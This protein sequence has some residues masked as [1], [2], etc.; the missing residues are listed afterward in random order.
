MMQ[1]DRKTEILDAF[2]H[3][4][5]RFGFDKTTMQDIAKEV[6][7]SVG[8]IY[9]DFSNKEDLIKEYLVRMN[10][11]FI[12]SGRKL[13][14]KPL[15]A[16]QLLREFMGFYLKNVT[17]LMIE[18]RGFKQFIKAEEHF[19]FFHD[20]KVVFEQSITDVI[21]EI[22]EKGVHEGVFKID[23]IAKTAVLFHAAFKSIF[24]EMV[25]TDGKEEISACIRQGEAL[26]GFLIKA[27]K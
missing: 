12:A 3:L 5:S 10:R 14:D 6:G 16:E 21:A 1:T 15:G 19:R 8:V 26:V 2:V 9:K 7:I 23:D 27:L 20:N 18:N 22:M 11:E 4:V 13:F 25:L 24:A 17:K